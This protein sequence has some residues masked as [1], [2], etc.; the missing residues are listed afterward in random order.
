MNAYLEGVLASPELKAA[1]QQSVPF[2]VSEPTHRPAEG[3]LDLGQALASH[4]RAILTGPARYGKTTLLLSILYEYAS[5]VAGR[6][7]VAGARS[8]YCEEA[9]I[10]LYLDLGQLA[11][12]ETLEGLAARWCTPLAG[13]ELRTSQVSDLLARR[14][15]LVLLD[16]MDR[17]VGRQHLEGLN[18]LRDLMLDKY[19]QQRYVLALP[20]HEYPL[21]EDWLPPAHVLN[22]MPLAEE[23]VLT[24]LHTQ[25]GEVQARLIVR[26][27]RT[28]GLWDMVRDPFL[29]S[30]IAGLTKGP[31][32]QEPGRAEI[33]AQ[34]AEKALLGAEPLRASLAEL[35]LALEGEGREEFDWTRCRHILDAK[36]EETGGGK[37]S[38]RALLGAGVL[39]S[40]PGEESLAFCHRGL[41]QFLAGQALAVVLERGGSLVS[42]LGSFS[43]AW[44][45]TLSLLYGSMP[46]P[47]RLLEALIT[48]ESPFEAIYLATFCVTENEPRDGLRQ[49]LHPNFFDPQVN[50]LLGKALRKLGYPEEARL[51]LEEA[52]RFRPDRADI[53][54]E[55]AQVLRALGKVESAL[56]S[57]QRAASLGP[58]S[59]EVILE[60]A[61]ERARGKDPAQA[62]AALEQAL[63]ALDQRKADTHYRLAE[64]YLEAGRFKEALAHAGEALRTVTSAVYQGQMGRVLESLG[65]RAEAGKYFRQALAQEPGLVVALLGL[66]RVLEEEGNLTAALDHFSA[67]LAR[68]P[69][70]P[71]H[72]LNVGRVYRLKGQFMLS[73]VYLG[74]ALDLDPSHAPTLAETGALLEAQARYN[75]A[76]EQ[77]RRAIDLRPG[78]AD[79]HYR[80]G[81][82]LKLAGRPGHAETELRA[83]IDLKPGQAEY[84]NQLGVVLTDLER[85]REALGAYQQASQL[86]PQNPL[87]HRNVGVALAQLGLAQEAL[88]AFDQTLELCHLP[89]ARGEPA[90][91]T[92][93]I[94]A[95]AHSERGQILENMGDGVAALREY[96]RAVEL[97]PTESAYRL[98]QALA[99]GHFSEPYRMLHILRRTVQMRPDDGLAHYHLGEALEAMG[100]AEESLE[101]YQ[102]AVEM[103]PRE[104]RLWK[105]LGRVQRT[106]GQMEDSVE[107]LARCRDLMP[108]DADAHYQLGLSL[109]GAGRG[110]EAEECYRRAARLDVDREEYWMALGRCCR[111]LGRLADSQAAL[112]RVIFL[113]PA[114]TAARSEMAETYLR[115]GRHQEALAEALAAIKGDP[116]VGHYHHQAARIY[117]ETGRD[118]DALLSLNKA[119]ELQPHRSDWHMELGLLLEEMG[120]RENALSEYEKACQWDPDSSRSFY[121]LGRLHHRLGRSL[122]AL[123]ELERAVALDP[124]SV[125]ARTFMAGLCLDRGD[126]QKALDHCRT[127]ME[128][129]P[130][131]AESFYLASRAL[132]KLGREAEAIESLEKATSLRPDEPAWLRELGQ[133]YAGAGRLLEAQQA[134]QRA[135]QLGA[136]PNLRRELAHLYRRMGWRQEAIKE[137]QKAL[138]DAAGQGPETRGL[139]LLDIGDFYQDTRD[140]EKSAEAYDAAR[141]LL[142]DRGEVYERRGSL[143]VCMGRYQEARAELEGAASRGYAE[144][145]VSHTLSLAL[146]G[147]GDTE[148]AL[149]QAIKA[150][151]ADPTNPQFQRHLG[152]VLRLKGDLN[153]AMNYLQRALDLAP[154][155]PQNLLQMGLALEDKGDVPEALRLYQQAVELSPEEPAFHLELGRLLLNLGRMEES[156]ADLQAAV[157]GAPESPKARF[158]LGRALEGLGS[159]ERAGEQYAAASRLDP[160][161]AVY[162]FHLGKTLEALGDLQDAVASL[163][164]ALELEGSQASWHVDLAGLYG[165]MG[166]TDQAGRE[167]RRALDL[168]PPSYDNYLQ[169]GAFYREGG[170]Y[171]EALSLLERAVSLAPSR[172]EGHRQLGLVKLDLGL[173]DEGIKALQRAVDLSLRDPLCQIDL[174][175]AYRLRG[176]HAEAAKRLLSITKEWPESAPAHYYLGLALADQ[177]WHGEALAPLSRA[178]ELDEHQ[179]RYRCALARSLM[180]LNQ[181]EEAL[182]QLREASAIP[183]ARS[184]D[185]VGIGR[186]LEEMGRPEDALGVYRQGLEKEQRAE[187]YYRA[188]GVLRLLRRRQDAAAS[189]RAALALGEQAAW[190]N[191]L[192]EL[193]EE[194]G[195]PAEALPCFQRALYLDPKE[196]LHHRNVGVALERLHRYEAAREVLQEAVKL[197]PDYKD[198][199]GHL[200][201][202][203]AKITLEREVKK[204][205]SQH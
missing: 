168:A 136:D 16:H 14:E 25:Y 77:L 123:E 185:L 125:E 149:R 75:E 17:L 153:S 170:L 132:L 133:V 203:T 138:E 18:A 41:R 103:L 71:G 28:R 51:E 79:Y 160:Q 130:G 127:I 105:S 11:S 158:T 186:I 156:L 81:W 121:L 106:L 64:M 154:G 90:L 139:W 177:R 53:H 117:K 191:E 179:P 85:H 183:S 134:C 38:C 104:G 55:H 118:Q 1:R 102:R 54:Y 199:L 50:F 112:R 73:K 120:E 144:P 63:E 146:L 166:E 32:P 111:G 200:A 101:A 197:R 7:D 174:A 42:I 39:R 96:Q 58:P 57:Y 5:Q 150:A 92:N 169:A 135:L 175:N 72:Y 10:P 164:Q 3:P 124:A 97:M 167:Y 178:A 34:V 131:Y 83:A 87:Y 76:A 80:L 9:R 148:G 184:E 35:A 47:K 128:V 82:L 19:P 108:A 68:E 37:E 30:V 202:V 198:A 89:G 15:C 195:Q 182:V 98:R 88:R 172:A 13:Q 194:E 155:D 151:F 44:A 46:Q 65:N 109:E 190:Q 24:F 163:R 113:N 176:D 196:P 201:S 171:R 27:L 122:E 26:L 91:L 49:A 188:A 192:G 66:G 187:L 205:S 143:L 165:R 93:L 62:A 6:D 70:E 61:L 157:E 114:H 74:T 129:A 115:Q 119:V 52:L 180:E 78:E 23:D 173:P 140:W 40:V 107:S 31:G 126:F 189:L 181:Q 36:K 116:E 142:G 161:V 204:R 59:S 152:S 12:S 33:L 86:E 29:L 48:P 147:L 145:R 67:A 99:Y 159:L 43:F 21:L 22:L 69:Q 84:H 4:G 56:N 137:L 141:A 45:E 20:E 94:A 95:D 8:S 60:I 193:L 110:L 2:Q 162:H 100:Q